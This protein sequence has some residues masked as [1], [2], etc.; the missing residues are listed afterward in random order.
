MLFT[1]TVGVNLGLIGNIEG[2]NLT[3]SIVL[4][5]V[6]LRFGVTRWSMDNFELDLN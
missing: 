5:F 6:F 3:I 2:V 1:E 4:S